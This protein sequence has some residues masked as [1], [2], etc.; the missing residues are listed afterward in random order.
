[1]RP[2]ILQ[3][4]SECRKLLSVRS[5]YILLSVLILLLGLF[6]YFG[7]SPETYEKAV[8]EPTGKVL[9]TR[10]YVD[11]R[12]EEGPP[13]DVCGGKVKYTTETSKDLAKEELLY[14]LQEA[15][16]VAVTFI[17]IILI[18]FVAHEFRYNVIN[19]TLT[20]SN[21][22]SKVLLAKLIVGTGFTLLATLLA[23][24]FSL[25]VSYAAIGI[26]DLNL[27]PQDYNWLYIMARHLVYGLGYA[28]FSMGVAVLV[29]NL[30]FA[31]A[32]SFVLP[33]IDNIAGFLLSSRD[34]EPTKT[35]P[36]TALD[37]FGNVAGDI[38]NRTA[39]MGER[40]LAGAT[41]LPATALGA[42]A[43]FA[44]YFAI[45]WL[46]TWLLFLRRDAN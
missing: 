12:L 41:T 35:L 40:A 23:I 15:V 14:G 37:R 46:L 9:Y 18:L 26:K 11:P 27:P 8:C 34:I 30:T 20:I 4:K 1:M 33:T 7:T 21:S 6:S 17:S 28:L 2:L 32:A 39:E 13:E 44:A 3:L 25:A 36:F 42:L 31:I 43:V 16:P 10:D 29:R 24:G 45:L 38:T 5:T 19:Y 22:R